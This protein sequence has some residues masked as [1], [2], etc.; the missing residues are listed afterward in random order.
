[1][2]FTVNEDV[3]KNS[4]INRMVINNIEIGLLTMGWLI[5]LNDTKSSITIPCGV[6]LLGLFLDFF[7]NSDIHITFE[8]SQEEK[9][10]RIVTTDK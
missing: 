9:R 1:M 2:S 6:N 4:K 3:C 8:S 10:A 7:T 5:K